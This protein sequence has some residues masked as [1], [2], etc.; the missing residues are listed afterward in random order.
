MY[1]FSSFAAAIKFKLP[2]FASDSFTLTVRSMLL[3]NSNSCYCVVVV[4]VVFCVCV[5]P[6][7]A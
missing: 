3:A 7:M 6:T 2:T 5:Y 1:R 4:V